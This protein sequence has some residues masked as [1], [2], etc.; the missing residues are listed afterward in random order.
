MY[1]ILSENRSSVIIFNGFVIFVLFRYERMD[2]I[3]KILK[4]KLLL[5]YC[6][7]L[8]Y[9]RNQSIRVNIYQLL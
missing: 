4:T 5:F 9:N 1:G 3:S 2:K 7:K 8:K 6:F